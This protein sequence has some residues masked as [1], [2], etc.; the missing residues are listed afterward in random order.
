MADYFYLIITYLSM[1]IALGEFGYCFF[2]IPSAEQ[3]VLYFISACNLYM[4]FGN[5]IAVSGVSS[6]ICYTGLIFTYL[7]GAHLGLC[8]LLLIAVIMHIKIDPHIYAFGATINAVWIIIAFLD[9][10]YHILY[11]K[12]EY[13]IGR[14]VSHRNIEY[15][16]LFYVFIAWLFLYFL[17][18]LIVIG[19]HYKEHTLQYM[20][21]K[22]SIIA[23]LISGVI[24]Y[25]GSFYSIVFSPEY[26]YTAVGISISLL[27]VILALYHYKPFA[28][29][30]ETDK[31]ILN[32]LD[33]LLFAY[34]S[35]ERLIY[36]NSKASEILELREDAVYGIDIHLL[37]DKVETILKLSDN[38]KITLGDN[39]YLCSLLSVMTESSDSGT[40]IWLQDITKEEKYVSNVL[41]LKQAAEKANIAKSAFL[42][43]ISHE[44]R[45]PINAVIGMDELILKETKEEMTRQYASN[46][47][48]AGTTLMSLINDVLDYSKIEAGKMDIVESEYDI[49]EM[50]RDLCLLIRFRAEQKNLEFKVNVSSSLPQLLKGD[51]L[52]I[53]QIITNILTNAVKYTDTGYVLLDVDYNR[54]DKEH[55]NLIIKVKDSGVG[56]KDKDISKLF[57][58]F[59][60]IESVSN[61]SIEGTGLGMSITTNLINMMHG[62]I[63]VVSE[64]TKGSEFTITI[65]QPVIDNTAIGD[66]SEEAA[67][68]SED[69]DV[70]ITTHDVNILVVDDNEMNRVI[71]REL[72]KDINIQVDD[73]SSGKEAL[74]M[75][76]NKH[77]DII[78][79]DHRMPE[80]TGVEV[81]E[82]ILADRNHMNVGVPVIIMT[83]D[84]ATDQKEMF[85]EKG[86]T[87]YIAKPIIVQQYIKT[88][89]KYIPKEKIDKR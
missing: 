10:R 31:D 32:K 33:D 8:F 37:G 74:E 18:I 42:A 56:I 58:S 66:F 79:L 45:T 14:L 21:V 61:H 29:S 84:V 71:A 67:P 11:T 51:A 22:K 60:R 7:G 88:L 81:L 16:P 73:V 82:H 75:I 50:I 62:T 89:L 72:I 48:R 43:H 13:S 24:S 77:F 4:N 36:N 3:K 69:T 6:D 17:I 15:A 38:D 57:G 25:V 1:L 39:I 34:D 65:P 47:K 41:T 53:K 68:T 76:K 54:L 23:Y 83:A 63:D 87:D 12:I 49:C 27:F 30:H 55:I 52:R 86:F 70:N 44:I 46:I 59:E 19:K 85:M 40:V 64:Y 26:D 5:C 2:K 80:M 9:M 78:I 28:L 35:E 20:V